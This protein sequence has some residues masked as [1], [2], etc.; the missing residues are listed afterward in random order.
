MYTQDAEVNY[1]FYYNKRQEEIS[2]YNMVITERGEEIKYTEMV[3]ID[4][5]GDIEDIEKIINEKDNSKKSKGGFLVYSTYEKNFKIK[6]KTGGGNLPYNFTDLFGFMSVI[7]Y[8]LYGTDTDKNEQSKQE[9]ENDKQ[10]K[11]DKPSK[12]SL[13]DLNFQTDYEVKSKIEA[14]SSA[15]D[16]AIELGD[17]ELFHKLSESYKKLKERL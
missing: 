15:I 14:L 11:Q 16:V 8:V 7:D 6:Y 1:R 4:L 10:G 17:K 12:L 5:S 9:G 13:K 2:G 3:E